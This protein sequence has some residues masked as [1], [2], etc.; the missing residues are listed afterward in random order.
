MARPESEAD[1]GASDAAAEGAS[2]AAGATGQAS[3]EGD[4]GTAQAPGAKAQPPRGRA[5]VAASPDPEPAA[6]LRQDWTDPSHGHV[7]VRTD[8]RGVGSVL[9]GVLTK[10]VDGVRLQ[11][12]GTALFTDGDGGGTTSVEVRGAAPDRTVTVTVNMKSTKGFR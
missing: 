8:D 7:E 9:I 2:D 12:G 6:P 1:Q 11:G 3:P 10:D 5:P 4:S